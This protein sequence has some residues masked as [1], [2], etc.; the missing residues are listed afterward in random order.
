[1]LVMLFLYFFYYDCE[2][3]KCYNFTEKDVDACGCECVKVNEGLNSRLC[4]GSMDS[5][6]ITAWVWKGNL[7]SGVQEQ[8]YS[9][10]SFV[11]TRKL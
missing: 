10:L 6:I 4:A 9:C 11:I 2:R 1:M 5:F 7:V 3:R 8:E